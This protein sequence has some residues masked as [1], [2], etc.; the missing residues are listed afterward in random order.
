MPLHDDTLA[1]L[2]ARNAFR[3]E[4]E[5]A[6]CDDDRTGLTPKVGQFGDADGCEVT[7]RAVDGSC[8][9]ATDGGATPDLC[10]LGEKAVFPACDSLYETTLNALKIDDDDNNVAS[11]QIRL[12]RQINVIESYRKM[13]LHKCQTPKNLQLTW[14]EQLAA[15]GQSQEE[16]SS[17]MLNQAI[18][19][20]VAVD[21]EGSEET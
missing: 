12:M 14:C 6:I 3:N 7:A 4:L 18:G 15:E 2:E 19:R 16:L 5:G 13:F 10:A 17:L 8:G 21:E 1:F 11:A 20:Q 9:E